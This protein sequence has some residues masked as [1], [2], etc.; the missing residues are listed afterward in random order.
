MAGTAAGAL[1]WGAS[2]AVAPPVCFVLWGV[3]VA[4]EAVVPLLATRAR[5]SLPLHLE[6]LPERFALFVILVLGESIAG[7]AHGISVAHWSAPSLVAAGLAFVLSAA[8]W[9]SYFDLAGARAKR[10]LQEAGGERS[11]HQHDIYVFGQLPLTL[12]L[13]GIGAGVQLAVQQAGAGEVPFGTRVLLAG[14]VAVYLASGS[15]TNS[16]MA[17]RS[18]R[19]WWWPLAAAGI[20]AVDAVL[21][22][23]AVVVV[24]A[25]DV[26]LI[27]VV[28]VGSV[29]RSADRLPVDP[30]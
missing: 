23:P 11:R 21:E 9:W 15:L 29:E 16:G 5:A 2:I 19:G 17:R 25:L 10:L 26:L 27:L 30:L 20:A 13:A 18:R 3:A 6:H 28:V 12:A 8:L 7:V 14:G 24:G 22:L 1:L 4:G